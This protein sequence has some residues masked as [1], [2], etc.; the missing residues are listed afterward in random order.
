MDYVEKFEPT[1]EGRFTRHTNQNREASFY[2]KQCILNMEKWAPKK[3]GT[4]E[5]KNEEF[6]DEY[7]NKNVVPNQR[8]L[9]FEEKSKRVKYS[10]G[11]RDESIKSVLP[12]ELKLL[13]LQRATV[14]ERFYLNYIPLANRPEQDASVQNLRKL[15]KINEEIKAETFVS[16]STAI[17]QIDRYDVTETDETVDAY[18]AIPPWMRNK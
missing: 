9:S 3:I 2:Y 8:N 12:P 5:E 13:W 1:T 10:F 18:Y 14:E 16:E 6:N 4:N 15:K 7:H 17:P 11:I